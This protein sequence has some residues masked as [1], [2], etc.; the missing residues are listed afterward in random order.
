MIN[1]LKERDVYRELLMTASKDSLTADIE[2]ND[3]AAPSRPSIFFIF[4]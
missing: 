3:S 2:V 1:F 4:R